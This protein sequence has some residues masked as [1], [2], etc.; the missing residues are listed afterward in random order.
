MKWTQDMRQRIGRHLGGSR[1]VDSAVVDRWTSD[2]EFPYLV[3]F[4]RT[5]SHWLRMVM[6]QT[7]DMPSLV[8]TFW[9]HDARRFSCMHV[10]DMDLEIE[11]SSVIYLH[12]EMT[13]TVFSQMRYRKLAL[14]N[15]ILVKYWATRYSMHLQKWL[16]EETFT[17]VKSVISYEEMRSAPRSVLAVVGG[18]LG[19]A[20]DDQRL[21]NSLKNVD[22]QLVSAKTLHDPAVIDSDE[23]KVRERDIFYEMAVDVIREVAE[24]HDLDPSIHV[25]T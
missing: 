21:T 6:E 22:H 1:S 23:Q 14:D 3:S 12:R 11:R 13:A 2:P 15:Q 5:G 7:F 9:L 8:R 10:H 19:L 24:R 20:V 17:T 4:P 18:H 25:A 16:Y